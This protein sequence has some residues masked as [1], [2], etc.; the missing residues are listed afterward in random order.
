M[1]I[2]DLHLIIDT[3]IKKKLIRY[4]QVKI[5]LNNLCKIDNNKIL[6]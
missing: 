6:N 2:K 4:N 3:K 1:Q 5:N